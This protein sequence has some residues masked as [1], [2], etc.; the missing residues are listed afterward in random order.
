M[1][2]GA[3]KS[4]PR[5]PFAWILWWRVDQDTIEKQA[6][7]YNRLKIHETSRGQGALILLFSALLSTVMIVFVNHMPLGLIDVGLFLGLAVFVFLGHRWAMI[8]AMVLWTLEKAAQL[9]GGIYAHQYV[10]P[11]TIVIWWTV[12][13]HIFFTAWRVEQYRRRNPDIALSTFD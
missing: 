13:M 1:P 12:Y 4:E 11:F 5:A 8:G 9:I 2:A 3:S 6:R 10:T 7:R